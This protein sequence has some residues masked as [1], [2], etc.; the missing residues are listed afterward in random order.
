M[1]GAGIVL[2]G[3]VMVTAVATSVDGQWRAVLFLAVT[4][5][6]TA[7]DHVKYWL[8]RG[9]GGRLRDSRLVARIGVAQWD[10]AVSM[11]Q[12][13]GAW[14]VLVSRLLPLVRT[15]MAA[16]AGASHLRYRSFAAASLVDSALWAAVWV[17]AGEAVVGLWGQPLLLIALIGLMATFVALRSIGRPRRTTL[18]ATAP[19]SGTC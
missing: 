8:G 18:S 10:R 5:G 7:G 4:V 2:P 3:E 12:R 15:L 11:V 16:V 19:A 17:A 6:A 1:L 14:A 13:R 9:L